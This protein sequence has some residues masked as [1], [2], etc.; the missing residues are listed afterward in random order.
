MTHRKKVR[1]APVFL[2][3]LGAIASLKA[4]GSYISFSSAAAEAQPV[5]TT[6]APS[7]AAAPAVR[8][9]ATSA[10]LLEQLDARGA[11][12]DQREI[13]L[14]TRENV[15]AAAELRLD[16]S[17]RTLQQEKEALA[18]ARDSRA[19]DQA[20][21]LGRLSDAYEKMKARDAAGVFEVLDNDILVPVAAG[22]RTQSLA[23]VLAEMAPEKARALTVALA[24]R[25]AATP[26]TEE[27]AQ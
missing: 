18:L 9:S 26:S 7:P 25:D 1:L 27:G 22:M 6:P 20:G 11:E 2:I 14:D 3:A 13:D 4:A 10:R 21:E 15:L 19:R 23:A 5:A 16:A 24:D 17:I 8:G 12:L